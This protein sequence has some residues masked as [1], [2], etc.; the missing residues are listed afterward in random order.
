EATA[1][2][3]RGQPGATPGGLQ[4]ASRPERLRRFLSRPAHHRRGV[5]RARGVHLVR[6]LRLLAVLAALSLLAAGSAFGKTEAPDRANAAITVY[7][8]ASLTDVFPK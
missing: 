7:A 2:T 6:A 5:Q 8:A 4:R 3:D 1:C